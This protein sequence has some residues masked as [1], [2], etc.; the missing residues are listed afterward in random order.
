MANGFKWSVSEVSLAQHSEDELWSAINVV[1][2]SR[3]RNTTT[4]KFCFLKA[5]LDN[6]YNVDADLVLPFSVVFNRMA[7]IYW[8]L[9]V[10]YGLKQINNRKTSAAE[11]I[12]NDVLVRYDLSEE[13]SFEALRP[14]L[15]QELCR[16]VLKECSANVVGALC[17]DTRQI[18]YG[19]D[20]RTGKIR[21]NG[22]AYRFLV[23]YAYVI[24][25]LNYFEWIKFLEMSNR[26]ESAFALASKLDCSAK[27]ENLGY[28]SD[29][30][31]ER[32]GAHRCFYCGRE[33]NQ[34]C[35][36]DHF[37]PWS[38]VKDDKAWN[39]VQACRDCNNH[40]RDK[41]TVPQFVGKV[42]ERNEEIIRM[43]QLLELVEPDFVGYDRHK[44]HKMYN[45]A[46]FN[47]FDKDW[48]PKGV[49]DIG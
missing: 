12:I 33:L 39:F 8:N 46:V 18:I 26:E 16:R 40:K 27:R 35:E 28:Y 4:Y 37:I 44:L 29:F 3:S 36:V 45:S 32:F 47:G 1:F 15:K 41:L 10:R 7:E 38:F 17:G 2:S 25:K 24:G 31:M 34:H 14:D 9:V 5:M 19:F 22:D 23:K 20:K 6:I 13:T 21:F 49:Y 48:Q 42:V 30:L 11:R 43:P